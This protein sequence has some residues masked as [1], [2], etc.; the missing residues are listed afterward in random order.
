MLA[1]CDFWYFNNGNT[2]TP[3]YTYLL[4]RMKTNYN[5]FYRE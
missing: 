3:K 5:Y 1:C 2:F 4:F